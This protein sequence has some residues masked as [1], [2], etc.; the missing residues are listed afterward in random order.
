[1]HRD[2]DLL[3]EMFKILNYHS[4]NIPHVMVDY[5]GP[6]SVEDSNNFWIFSLVQIISRS[7]FLDLTEVGMKVAL[8]IIFKTS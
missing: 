2:V 4:S 3:E 1:M 7:S 6:Q 8:P 5:W